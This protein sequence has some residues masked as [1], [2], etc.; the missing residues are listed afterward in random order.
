MQ[1][2]FVYFS[3]AKNNYRNHQ[4]DGI[5][6]FQLDKF[7]YFATQGTESTYVKLDDGNSLSVSNFN[8][9]GETLQKDLKDSFMVN[10]R[11]ASRR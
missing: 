8:V 10:G 2:R 4:S 11:L 7:A 9:S 3:A 5:A 6:T 1:S